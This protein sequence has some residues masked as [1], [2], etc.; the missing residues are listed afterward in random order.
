MPEVHLTDEN[1]QSEIKEY[2]GIAL[3]DFWAPWC[4]PCRMVGPIIEEIAK[5]MEGKVKVGKVNVDEEGSLAQE[6]QIQSIPMVYIFKD[7]EIVDDV[8]GLSPKDEYLNAL[9]KY[10]N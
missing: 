3:V 5:E 8:P 1:F 4:G 2:K 9:K 6:F 7:G 10:I